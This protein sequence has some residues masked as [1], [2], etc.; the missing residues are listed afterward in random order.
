MTRPRSELVSTEVTPYYHCISRCVRRAYLYGI[1]SHTGQDFRHRK[2]WIKERLVQLQAVF[3]VNLCAY[4]IM[5][6]HYHLVIHID[7]EAAKHFSEQEVALRWSK[8]FRLPLLVKRYL[9]TNTTSLAEQKA[10]QR[11]LAERR[12]RL[13]DLSWFMR[14]LNEHIARKAN[15]EDECTGRF[16]EGRFRSQAI[17]DDAGLLACMAYVDLNPLRAGQVN[18][19]EEATEVSLQQ[20]IHHYHTQT[21]TV[22]KARALRKKPDLL[23]FSCQLKS[24]LNYTDKPEHIPFTLTDYLSLI[25]W[26]SRVQTNNNAGYVPHFAPKLLSR[27]NVSISRFLITLSPKVLSR[28]S[29]IGHCAAKI[30]YALRHRRR[31][32]IGP[33]FS[34]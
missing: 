9:A 6:N 19:P 22:K 16:W 31:C 8:L 32:V 29:V 11:Y 4:A 15:K 18:A 5:D 34:A 12:A 26:V 30:A 17:L 3:T 10:A 20:R 25:D 23:P 33:S 14:C 7:T 21:T 24:P 2:Q 13:A 27:M 1:D 28:G